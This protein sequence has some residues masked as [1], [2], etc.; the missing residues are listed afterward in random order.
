METTTVTDPSSGEHRSG[1]LL[2]VLVAL[3]ANALLAVVKT[4]AALLTGSAALVAEAA[5][6]WADT[7]NE[8]LLLI[9]ERS[10]RRASDTEHPRGYGR[11]TYSWSL[12]AAFGLF[13]AG[14]V[15]SIYHGLSQL[16]GSAAK[17]SF[18]ITYAVLGI[19]FVLESTSF[20][21]A[22][23]QVRRDARRAGVPALR[24]VSTTSD[25]TVRAVFLEDSAAILGL[26]IAFAA[27]AAHQAT[28]DPVYDAL[29][30]IGVGL[31]LGCV[32]AFLM[33]RNLQYLAGA[34][35]SLTESD[36]LL[37][38]LLA[39]PDVERVTYLHAE[40]VGPGR[41]F[42]VAAVRLTGDDGQDRLATRLRDVVTSLELDPAVAAAVLTPSSPTDPTL[43]PWSPRSR[44]P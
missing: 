36:R 8:G 43:G 13:T 10:G 44:P 5:H 20:L 18:G 6:S 3:S 37:M 34:G 1:S 38:V 32:A 9:A 17:G 12:V 41:L 4:G 16:S 19:A 24:Y 39:Q 35:P 33:R 11:S 15:F 25:P 40:Y 7:G 27:V 31:L 28:G 23:R 42:V 29:G 21:Q 2:T 22:S 14:A 30:S 26:V